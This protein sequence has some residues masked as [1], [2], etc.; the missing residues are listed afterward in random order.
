MNLRVDLILESERRSASLINP[1]S[2]MRIS[3]IIGPVL[4]V[5]IVG[6]FAFNIWQLNNHLDSLKKTLEVEL[7]KKERAVK[8][9]ADLNANLLLLSE[10]DGWQKSRIDWA[11]QLL[12]IQKQ[13]PDKMQLET[14]MVNHSIQLTNDMP[15]RSFTMKL[16]GKAVG[17]AASALVTQLRDNLPKS[18]ASS[19]SLMTHPNVTKFSRPLVPTEE[20]RNDRI[21]QID[22][23]YK[24]RMFE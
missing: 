8:I 2:V 10:L 9:K 23:S 13:V 4:L 5:I 12:G 21:F 15:C 24:P 14:L 22:C 3:A 6:T 16:N 1:K 11:D 18:S 7:P 20:N 19:N 17:E